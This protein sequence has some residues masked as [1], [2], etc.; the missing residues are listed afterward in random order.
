MKDG[1][2]C[3]IDVSQSLKECREQLFCQLGSLTCRLE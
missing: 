3:T 2:R 1:K